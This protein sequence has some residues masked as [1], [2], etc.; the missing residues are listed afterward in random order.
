ME[1]PARAVDNLGMMWTGRGAPSP[2]GN[3]RSLPIPFRTMSGLAAPPEY[4]MR[5]HEVMDLL[6]IS[7]TTLIDWRDKGRIVGHR[8]HERAHWRYP[9]DQPVIRAALDAVSAR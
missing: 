5:P 1:N 7:K 4:L 8:A 2:T 3:C 6:R 9:A